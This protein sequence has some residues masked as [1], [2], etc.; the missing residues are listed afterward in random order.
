MC[1]RELSRVPFSRLCDNININKGGW[2]SPLSTKKLSAKLKPEY[3]EYELYHP[4]LV[5]SF[6]RGIDFLP[7]HL[8]AQLGAELSCQT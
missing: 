3:P 5:M 4:G 8:P 6:V 7:G 1:T 2:C